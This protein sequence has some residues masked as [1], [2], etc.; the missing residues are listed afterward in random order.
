MIKILPSITT[1]GVA[2][3]QENIDQVASLGINEVA[4]FVSFA[5]EIERKEIYKKLEKIPDLQ[6]P[7]CHIRSDMPKS[8]LLYLKQKFNTDL[9]NIHTLKSHPLEY[10]YGELKK[11]ILIENHAHPVFSEQEITEFGGICLDLA[12]LENARLESSEA[13]EK[14]VRLIEKFSVRANHL[15]AIS[16]TP[17]R[18]ENE[19]FRFDEHL[20]HNFREFDYI[21]RY[22]DNYF[23]KYIILELEN[24]INFQLKIR[25]YLTKILSQKLILAMPN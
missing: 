7:F 8:E 10:E 2:N 3:W 11:S 4:L 9:F 16:F 20:D 6:I 24:S 18:I 1:T 21:L 19:E 13:F 15:S 22:P 12:H 5:Q 14:T 17:V 23:G 25:D